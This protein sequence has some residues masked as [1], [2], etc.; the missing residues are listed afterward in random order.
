MN[1]K[2]SALIPIYNVEAYIE[3][4]AR[5]LFEQTYPNLEYVFVNDCTPDR[6]MDI[7]KRAMEDYPERKGCVKIINHERNHGL[8]ATRNTCLD[9]VTGEF[10]TVVDSD[11]WLE[12]KAVELLV[13]R[14]KETD[15]DIVSGN[16]IVHRS[17]GLQEL[18]EPNYASKEEMVLRQMEH[19]LDHVLWHRLIRRSVI[20]QHHIRAIEGSEM[21]EDRYQMTLISYYARSFAKTSHVIYNYNQLKPTL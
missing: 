1:Y 17:S 13:A 14:Q 2:V 10:V 12:P 19:T 9:N 8:A 18:D 15:A 3:R 7:L 6:S 21:A 20:E 5:S 16:A 4:C 11:D